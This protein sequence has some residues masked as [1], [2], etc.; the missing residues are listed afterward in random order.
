M[1]VNTPV[2]QQEYSLSADTTLMSTTDIKSHITYANSAFIRVSGFD[3]E[4]L[5]GQPHNIVRHPDMPPAAF[6]D[7]WYTLQQGDS[8]TGMV[9]NRRRN[10]DYY[11]VRANVTPV[12]HNDKLSGYISVRNTPEAEEVK[13]AAALYDAVIKQQAGRRKFYKGLVVRTG[14]LSV[15]SLFQKMPVRWRLRCAVL[16]G[17]MIPFLLSLSGAGILPQAFA[18]LLTML[19]LD[20]FLQQQ[21]AR[22][23]QTL[24]RQAQRVVSGRKVDALRFN[25][26]DEIGMLLRV[27]NQFSLNLNSLVDDVSTQV[28]GMKS[29]SE[30]LAAGNVDLSQ[31]TEETAGN[32]QQTAAAIEE[33]TSAVHQSAETAANAIQLTD[34]ATQAA[35]QGGDIMRQTVE[36]MSAINAASAKV[37]DIIAVIDS[38]AF[39][40]NI[41]ALNAA[42]EA[43]RAGEQGK[44]FAVVAAEVRQLA[45]NSASAAKEIK[46]LIDDNVASVQNG[47]HLVEKADQHI[48]SIVEHV[49]QVSGLIH[50]IGLATREQT[51]ALALINDSIAQIEQM[52]QS[53]SEMVTQSSGVATGLKQQAIRL[54]EAVN[55][56]GR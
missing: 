33:I 22:P 37:V 11:W 46:A 34:D 30:Q 48:S 24:L 20:I 39:Q 55:V 3:A 18:S 21:I 45:Q 14:L 52:T 13:A 15:L 40:T 47:S 42:V 5:M 51:S 36:M 29:V 41:L 12:Y 38:I 43:A 7:M 4:E 50:E 19:L 9:K 28:A 17:G 31:R 8:W 26:V 27:V 53:N 6:A 1:R 2:T 16:A 49:G 32:L 23:L 25:R 35:Q 54:T 10:G 56:Y 44:G